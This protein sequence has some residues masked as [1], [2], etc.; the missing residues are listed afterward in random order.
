[1]GYANG[2]MELINFV[3]HKLIVRLDLRDHYKI[4]TPPKEDSIK[5]DY[6]IYIPELSVTAVKYSPS[7][8][9]IYID[10]LIRVV[11]TED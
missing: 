2:I 11:V 5:G 6:D 1:M 9:I 10:M 8:T 4:I 7:G 3:S